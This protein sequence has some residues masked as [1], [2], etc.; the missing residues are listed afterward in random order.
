MFS[1]D[2]FSS[3]LPCSSFLQ[4]QHERVGE[5]VGVVNTSLSASVDFLSTTHLTLEELDDI[6]KVRTYWLVRGCSYSRSGQWLSIT[7]RRT[8]VNSNISS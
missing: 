5:Q 6:I 4:K 1:K 3:S 8:K 2:R 7:K